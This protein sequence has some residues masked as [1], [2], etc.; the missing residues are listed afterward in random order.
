MW[1]DWDIYWRAKS[2]AEREK[3]A[4]DVDASMSHLNNL[5]KDGRKIGPKLALKI[6]CACGYPKEMLRPDIFGEYKS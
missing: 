4:R 1:E 5:G 6:H 3:L 2:K